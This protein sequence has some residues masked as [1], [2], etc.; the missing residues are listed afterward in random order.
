MVAA[1]GLP[2]TEQYRAGLASGVLISRG[3]LRRI[4]PTGVVLDGPGPDGGAVPSQGRVADALLEPGAAAAGGLDRVTALTGRACTEVSTEDPRTT[5][6]TPV[7]TILWAT[8]FRATLDHLAPLHVRERGGGVV[9]HA[10][11]VSVA[12]RP[13]LFLVGYGASASTIG[14]TRA[15]RRAAV[16]AAESVAG[17]L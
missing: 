15:G 14:A 5:W 1:T 7:D 9:M 13:G 11:G 10:D 16:G 4:T 2:V 3:P 8:G 6:E 12:K 17:H